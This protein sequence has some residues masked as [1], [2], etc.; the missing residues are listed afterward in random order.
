MDEAAEWF[1]GKP[2]GSVGRNGLGWLVRF[3]NPYASKHFS[4]AAFGG[5]LE[6]RAA[7]REYQQ[8]ESLERGQTRNL[9]R[10]V[11]GGGEVYLG[12]QLQDGRLMKCDIEDSGLVERR[13]WCSWQSCSGNNYV[14][15]SGRRGEASER[16]HRLLCPEWAKVDHINRDGLD[17]RRSN[18]R[19]GGGGVNERNAK[20]RSDNTSGATG[21]SYSVESKAWVVQWSEDKRRRMKRF[22]GAKDDDAAKERAIAFRMEV[23]TRTGNANGV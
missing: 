14:A 16:F 12:V 23:N 6:S 9:M 8:S 20:Q 17:N 10:I 19:D 11:Q 22:P 13:T 4:D 2:G 1:G 5:A 18:L 3:Q 21:V 15:W 7:A